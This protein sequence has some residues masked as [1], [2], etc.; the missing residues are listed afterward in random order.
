MTTN[1]EEG[2]LTINNNNSNNN[3]PSLRVT[4]W[5]QSHVTEL[6]SIDVGSEGSEFTRRM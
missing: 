4:R 5:I 6:A 1:K 2:T 3:N